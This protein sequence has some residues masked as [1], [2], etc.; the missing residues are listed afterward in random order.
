M[1]DLQ[2]KCRSYCDD[3]DPQAVLNIGAL[4]LTK[5]K[6]AF[7]I[8]RNLVLENRQGQRPGT[9]EATQGAAGSSEEVALLGQQVKDLR[10]LLLQRDSEINILVNMVKQGKTLANE[11][12]NDDLSPAPAT[13]SVSSSGGPSSGGTVP[14][15][16]SNKSGKKGPGHVVQDEAFLQ[17]QRREKAIQ[18]LLFG[19][20]PPFS[21]SGV[22]QDAA[23][24]FEWFKTRCPLNQALEQNKEVLKERI[25]EAKTLGERANQSRNTISYLKNSIEAIRRER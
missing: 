18:R 1:E 13:P 24:S 19:I 15:T 25:T 16:S 23:L 7:A 21:D 5:I 20:E 14:V 8:F 11:D 17:Q 9:R 6:D 22:F 4:T 12:D 2:A 3:P 10:A